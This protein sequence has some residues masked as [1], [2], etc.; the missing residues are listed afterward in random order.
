MLASTKKGFHL[1]LVGTWLTLT[2]IAAIYFI[3][4][5][6]AQFDPQ[7]KLLNTKHPT[8]MESVK[9][10]KGLV[11]RDLTK[12]VVH[13]TAK[14]CHCTQ[15]SKDHKDQINQDAQQS[16][17]KVINVELDERSIIPSTPAILITDEQGELMYLGP[18]SKGLSCS[19]TNGYVELVMNNYKEGFNT[20]LVLSQVKGCYCNS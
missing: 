1:A 9:K 13:F 18:Y 2:I 15:F 5:R 12:T 10:I 6:I 17:F 8:I 3:S 20:R 4:E 16:N 14:G 19:K 11:K 7:F